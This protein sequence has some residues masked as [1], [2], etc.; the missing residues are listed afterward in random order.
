MSGELIPSHRHKFALGPIAQTPEHTASSSLASIFDKVQT[1]GSAE[2]SEGARQMTRLIHDLRNKPSPASLTIVQREER[3]EERLFDALANVKILT[4]QVSMHLDR[5]WRDKLFFQIDSLHD[6]LEW[7]AD[8]KPIQQSSFATF[9]K[10][11]L[12][13]KPARRPGLGLSYTGNL[14]AAWTSGRDRL[15]IEFLPKDS[16]RWVL[17]RY[18]DDEPERYAGHVPVYRLANGLTPHIPPHLFSNEI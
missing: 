13:I 4:A 8:D 15:T 14:I 7:D 11:I 17:T 3:L 6:P 2:F 12:Q 18:H 5:E 9:L 10:A 16:V 1:W